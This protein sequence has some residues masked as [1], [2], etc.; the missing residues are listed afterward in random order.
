[1]QDWSAI[2][3]PTPPETPRKVW[4]D[5]Y[6]ADLEK[7][8]DSSG[9]MTGEYVFVRSELQELSE[10]STIEHSLEQF[11]L[12][13]KK[14]SREVVRIYKNT[15]VQVVVSNMWFK[16]PSSCSPKNYPILPYTTI[17]SSVGTCWYISQVL[18]Q[19]YPTV[20]FDFRVLCAFA[21]L[22][23]MSIFFPTTKWEGI[24]S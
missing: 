7:K 16:H 4:T 23:E 22:W 1:M 13:P 20:P 17:I 8:V 15:M 5:D 10:D 12:L 18:S 19:G 2:N 6:I 14:V 11:I 21:F 3:S 24:W 9:S